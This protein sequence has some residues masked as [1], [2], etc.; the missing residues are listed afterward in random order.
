MGKTYEYR[1]P[2]PAVTTDSVVFGFD[3]KEKT[4]N[5]RGMN[6]IFENTTK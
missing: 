1:Y 6:K 4:T 2:H 5:G 3:G